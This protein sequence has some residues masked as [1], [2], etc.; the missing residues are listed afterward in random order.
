MYIGRDLASSQTSSAQHVLVH[1]PTSDNLSGE[2]GDFAPSWTRAVLH[3]HGKHLERTVAVGLYSWIPFSGCMFVSWRHRCSRQTVWPTKYYV[4]HRP[5][6][7]PKSVNRRAFKGRPDPST[8]VP[9][10]TPLVVVDCTT[11]LYSLYIAQRYTT[12]VR[13][14]IGDGWARICNDKVQQDVELSADLN[15]KDQCSTSASWTLTTESVT[16]KT[17]GVVGSDGGW[18]KNV[19]LVPWLLLVFLCFNP[20]D[21]NLLGGQGGIHQVRS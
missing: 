4:H 21:R 9:R 6:T 12:A 2:D 11:R 17:S 20:R 18:Q 15:P 8:S 19:I 13:Y 7:K 16:I 3:L 10:R 14:C 1:I 5:N